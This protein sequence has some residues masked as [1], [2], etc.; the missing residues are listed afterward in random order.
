MI[1]LRALEPEDALTL[2]R[3]ENNP[4]LWE[5]GSVMAPVSLAQIEN[6]I[7]TYDSNPFGA[8]E[9]RLMVED[10]TTG[11]TV[12]AI[13][14]TEVDAVNRRSGLGLLIAS[15]YSGQ[16]Y[17]HR[18]VEALENY[19]SERLGLHQ[20]WCVIGSENTACRALFEGLGY[21]ISGRLRSWL[22]HGSSYED[23]FLY[24]KLL[25]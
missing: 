8:G 23:A 21:K 13:D 6:Y 11:L 17:G 16:G 18:A 22:R 1:R 20:L 24:Q 3:W 19:C 25:L 2:Y 10:E 5:V 7:A 12:G 4:R 9:L 14:L 15:E